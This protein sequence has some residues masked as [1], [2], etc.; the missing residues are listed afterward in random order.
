MPR[1]PAT[2][3]EPRARRR[4]K[5]ARPAELVAAALELFVEKGYAATRLDDVARRAGVAKGTV[6]L[7]FTNKEALFD[8]VIRQA[9]VPVL[10]QGEQRV[11]RHKGSTAELLQDVLGNWMQLL[12]EGPLSRIPKLMASDADKFP[13]LTKAFH[14]VVLARGHDLLHKVLGRG[15]KRGEFRKIDID[16]AVEVLLSAIWMPAIARHSPGFHVPERHHPQAYFAALIDL[17]LRGLQT[18][19]SAPISVPGK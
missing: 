7:Y 13:E 4:R 15:V 1:I 18:T 14:D 5:A 6:Y 11:D 16:S 17:V 10:E 9:I 19:P 2:T 8:G 3:E 12:S